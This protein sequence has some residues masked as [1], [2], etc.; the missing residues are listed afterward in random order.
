MILLLVFGVL[1]APEGG[2]ASPPLCRGRPATIVG[3]PGDDH[4]V[5]T[6]G[7]DVIAGLGGDDTIDGGN[8]RDLIC[9]GDG[10]DRLL[11]GPGADVLLGG[12][13]A[14]ILS[15]GGGADRLVGGPGDDELAG[16]RGGD[17]LF[18]G[19]GADL[20]FGGGGADRLS[21]GPDRDRADGGPGL[22]ACV[23]EQRVGCGVPVAPPCPAGVGCG[24]EPASGVLDVPLVVAET[25]GL[26][27]DGAPVTSG[28][29]LPR[30][31]GITDTAGLR[32]LDAA[33]RPVAAQFTALARWGGAPG[34]PAA[35]LRWLLVDFQADLPAGGRASFRL[36]DSG[37]AAAAA[38]PLLVRDLPEVVRVETGA[39]RFEVSRADGRLTAPGLVEPAYVRLVLPDGRVA[40]M[41]GPVDVQVTAAGPLRAAVE[42]SG[43]LRPAAGPAVLG[44][45]A[46]YWFYAG[47]AEVR[48]FL[49]VENR[50]PCPLGA[51]AQIS[52]HEIGSAGSRRFADLSLVLPLGAGGAPSYS[53]GGETG[54]VSGALDGRLLLQQ[55]SSGT[56][57]WDAYASVSDWDGSPLDARP[58]LQAYAESRGYHTT[59]GGA[60]VDAGDHAPGFL[61][62]GGAAGWWAVEVAGFWE[63]FPKSLRAAPGGTLEVGLFPTEY[64]PGDFAYTLRAGEHKTHEIWLGWSPGEEPP[65]GGEA[66]VAVAPAWWYV[67]SGAAGPTA[68]PGGDWPDY[69]A[70]LAAQLERAPAYRGWMDWHANLLEAVEAT[71]FY[72]LTDYGDWPIDYEGYGLSPLN[73]KYDAGL[74]AWLQW[75]RTGD[76]RWRALAEAGNRHFADADVLHTLHSPRHWSDGIAFGH[77]YHDETGFE[78]PHRNYGGTHP[79]TAFGPEGLLLTYYLTGYPPALEA[80]L[81]V[82]DCIEYRLRNDLHLC[83]YLGACS[84]EGWALEDGLYLNGERPAANSLSIVVEAFRATGD[85]RYREVADALV[86][87]AAADAQPYLDG[88]DGTDRFLKP[89]ALGLYLRALADYLEVLGEFDLPDAAGAEASYLAY[90]SWLRDRAL[91]PLPPADS[92]P[93]AALPYEWWF[94]GRAENDQADITNWLLLAA[95]ALAYAHHLAGD[96][97]HLEAAEALFRAGSI[98]PWYEGDLNTYSSTK[99]T[100]NAVTWGHTFLWEWAAAGG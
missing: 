77:S 18:G 81:E 6:A 27:R 44:Y 65:E 39:A 91:I 59:L 72:G 12:E 49:T 47:R 64:G 41:Q 46:R 51:D 8:G 57:S 62:V 35:P 66:L 20:L 28:V 19:P 1:A 92:G 26:A 23:A 88:P 100:A 16:E 42:V 25:S 58:R 15:G 14:D 13:G 98:D 70:Y 80:A 55:A 33:G 60:V 83:P 40:D 38:P 53:V 54:L 86:A 71:D 30:E 24:Q 31:L 22:D 94:D 68:L 85:E 36:V 82:A 3:T 43:W 50:A 21:G 61:A 79:D 2:A 5:G 87:W 67:A 97:A 29:P 34:D 45:T 90:A 17:A 10:D 76:S 11:G 95:D 73:L 74:G 99:E 69:E 93:R 9:G 78:N 4:L 37:G 32:L 48:L 7:A 84:G 52:C 63:Q 96:A 89:W 56:G 75:M